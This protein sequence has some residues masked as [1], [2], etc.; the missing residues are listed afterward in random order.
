MPPRVAPSS[1][2][3]SPTGR[4]ELDSKVAERA[5]RPQTITLKNSFFAG[6][7]GRGKTWATIPTLLQTAKMNNVALKA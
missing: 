6:S 5:I 1:S 3:F 7:D 2:V 4:I